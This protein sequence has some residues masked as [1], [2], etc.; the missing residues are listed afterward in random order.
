MVPTV[1]DLDQVDGPVFERPGEPAT[2]THPRRTIRVCR[3]FS[4]LPSFGRGVIDRGD[5]VDAGAVGR[6]SRKLV[7]DDSPW[8]PRPR[9]S[10]RLHRAWVGRVP[11][12]VRLVGRSGR[13][14]SARRARG[15][16]PWTARTGVRA[17][18][19]PAALPGVGQQLRRPRRGRAGLVVVGQG[20]A[21]GR[22]A[23]RARRAGRRAAARRPRRPSSTAVHA[24]RSPPWARRGPR[25]VGRARPADAG[26]GPTRV[27]ESDLAADQ[28]AAVA[29]AGGPARVI[30]PAG[31]GKTRVLTERLR[32]LL[33]PAGY[34]RESVLAVAYNVR[35]RD[36]LVERTVGV[37][38]SG[39]DAQRA[40]LRGA[41]RGLGGAPAGARRA[42]G[43][44][45]H[46]PA[47]ARPNGTGGPT[48]TRSRRTSRRS[49]SPASPC[50]TR[51]TSRS[52]ATTCRDWPMIFDPVPGGAPPARAPST[53]T[54][55]STT[56]SNCCWPTA[57]CGAGLQAALSSPAGRRVPGSDARPTCCCSGCSP[58]RGST[59]SASATTTR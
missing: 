52:S 26:A 14:P 1:G 39:P 30:A 20:H 8:R 35:A 19:R 7:I 16:E 36:E 57:S 50:A 17:V 33:G 42:R 54:S 31:Q 51:P 44:P 22:H 49:A 28:R 38:A 18:A 6:P 2:P 25:R 43:P 4:L 3:P 27:P 45:H 10:S 58:H 53:S 29:H 15:R 32:H 5:Q 9:W 46:R 11:V 48:P 40:R 24:A 56:P 23:A 13:F 59:C 47:A 41:G 55:R 37:P 34:E 12:V 21:A